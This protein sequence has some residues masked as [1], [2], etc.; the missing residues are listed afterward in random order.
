MV[1]QIVAELGPWSWWIAGLVL[2]ILEV[3]AP[4]VFFLWIGLAA[5]VIGTVALIVAVPWQVQIIS[6]AILAL[7]FAVLGR[8][9][10]AKYGKKSDAP[11]LNQRGSQFIGRSYTLSDDLNGGEGRLKIGDTFWLIRGP[12]GL[13]AGSKVKV[14]GTKGTVLLVEAI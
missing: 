12:E 10:Y 14:T 8:K 7:V 11:T 6:F 9:L 2:L 3:L 4:G 13:S 1:D 5:I